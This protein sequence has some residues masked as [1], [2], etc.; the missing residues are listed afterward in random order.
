M[1]DRNTVVTAFK[2]LERH[3]CPWF[4]AGNAVVTNTFHLSGNFTSCLWQIQRT[5]CPVN[6]RHR[7]K[8]VHTNN[9][10][11]SNYQLIRVVT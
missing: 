3:P 11:G 5:F 2:T 6:S 9:A 8:T 10:P 1:G 7:L 4:L